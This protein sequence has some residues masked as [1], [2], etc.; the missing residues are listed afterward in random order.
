MWPGSACL[1]YLS[2]LLI[3]DLN[4]AREG[5][6]LDVAEEIELLRDIMRNRIGDSRV[7]RAQSIQTAPP[8]KRSQSS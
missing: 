1:D 2:S 7:L 6:S 4:G 5:F 3:D 8:G